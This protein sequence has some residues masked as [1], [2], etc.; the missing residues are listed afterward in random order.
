ML[1]GK[2]VLAMFLIFTL[3]FSN[4]AFVAE[5]FASTGFQTIFSLID[6]KSQ[7]NIEFE[8]LL[9]DGNNKSA[10]IVSD[11]NSKNLSLELKLNVKNS[12]YLKDGKVALVT[13][14]KELNFVIKEDNN[15]SELS[16]VQSLAENTLELKKIESSASNIEISLPIEYKMEEYINELKLDSKTHVI[17]T[18]IYVDNDGEEIEISKENEIELAWK[19]ERTVKVENEVSKFIKF[20]EN[21]AILQTLIKVDSSNEEQNSLPI[22]ETEL[23]INIP[24]INNI[25]PTNVT[26][27]ANSTAGTNGKG[28]G[29]VEFSNDNWNYNETEKQIN[30]KVQNKKE[31]VNINSEEYLKVEGEEKQEERYF[32]KTGIDEYIVTYTFENV[33]F[34]NVGIVNSNVKAN[35]SILSGVKLE[36]NE[37]I[38]EAE[39]QEKINLTEQTGNIVSYNIENETKDISKIYGYLN[40]EIELKSKT[41]INISYTDILEEIVVE[42]LENYYTDKSGDKIATN[43]V[44]YKQILV[45]KDNFNEIL[46]ENG[47]IEILDMAGNILTTINNNNEVDENGNYVVN[48]QD[49]ISKIQI[50]TSK[51]V[52]TGNLVVSNVKAVSNVDMKKSEYS[53]INYLLT[54]TIQKA[55]FTYVQDYVELGNK[56]VKTILNDTTTDFNLSID[57]QS[58]STATTN[59]DV[60]LRLELNNDEV[61]SDL[62]GNSVFEIEMP[63][64]VISMDITNASIIYGE[65]LN[66]SNIETFARDNKIV[67]KVEVEGNQTDLNSGVLTNGT[68][69]VLNTDIDV[70]MYA[71]SQENNIKAYCYNSEAT[72][73]SNAVEYII[74]DSSIAEY[75]EASI[76]YLA[77]N[78]VV[79]IN[80]ISN[81]DQTGKMITSI[82]EGDK[83]DYIDIYSNAKNATME[84]ALINNN[85]NSISNL[86]ILGRIPFEGVTDIENGNKLGTTLNAKLLG[87][88]MANENNNA[89]FKVY[90]SNNPNATKDLLDSL[91]GWTNNPENF[92][93][94][95]SYLIVPTDSSYVM[96]EKSVLRFTY[97]FEIPENLEHNEN[98]YGTFMAYYTN[99]TQ[100][101]TIEE[102]A[103][104]DKV[105]IT[106]G[107]GP[108]LNLDIMTDTKSI[109]ALDTLTSTVVVKN[110]GEDIVN[111]V[112]VT[113]PVPENTTFVSAKPNVSTATTT[114]SDSN[115][116]INVEKLEK[117]SSVEVTLKLNINDITEY[118]SDKFEIVA[119]V[120]AK[121]LAKSLIVKSEEIS[122]VRSEIGIKQY[123]DYEFSEETFRAGRELN[124]VIYVENLTDKKLNNINVETTLPQ[125]LKF[126]EGYVVNGNKANYDSSSN[127]VTWNIPSLSVEEGIAL[128]LNVTVGELASGINQKNVAVM[129]KVSSDE[130]ESYDAQNMLVNVGKT[131]VTI[132]QTSSTSTYVKEGETIDYTFI[133]KNEGSTPATDILLKES[134]P[135]GVIIRKISY[136]VDGAEYVETMSETENAEVSLTV[137]A[138]SE[139][140]VNV[141]ALASTLQDEKEKSITNVATIENDGMNSMTSNSVTHIIQ[142]KEELENGETSSTNNGIIS[143]PATNGDIT[144]SY[145]ITGT[146]WLD[147]NKNGMRDD[148]ETRMSNITAMLVESSTGTI[149]S[150]T[151]TSSN[152]EYTFSGVQNGS[153][154]VLFKYD[155]V[156]YTTTT[157][158]KEGVETSVNSD[159]VTTKIEQDGKKENGAV[160]DIVSVNGASISNIDIGLV[161]AD[162]FSLELDKTISKI[163]VQNSQGTKTEEFDNTKLA[164][165]DIAAKYL[166]GTKVYIEYKFTVKNNG[167][168]SGYASEIV[169]YIPEGMTFNSNLNPDW[170]TG[171]NGNLYTKALANTEIASGESK[172][173]TLVLTK[174]MTTEN[175]GLVS[176]TAEISDDYNIYG[177]SDTNSTPSNKAQGEDDIS[178]ADTIL[179]VKTGESLIYLSAIIVSLLIGSMITVCGIKI[180]RNKRKGGV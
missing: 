96:K 72:N 146:A 29:E 71:P 49:K 171:I 157:Y 160:T 52:N 74:K 158:R 109:R 91:N 134:I 30:I 86:A 43:D 166:S 119:T 83:V 55:K 22:K 73:Y 144:K 172:T 147:K 149:K 84:I 152:G 176:N 33:D 169:D 145:K 155:T 66:I 79:A 126:L 46:G 10:V 51:L 168:L 11:V 19:D 175:T 142:A 8:A 103:K 26:V 23:N 122:I 41:A 70:D 95:K 7:D 28:V 48:F 50:K 128:K 123:M 148:G 107:A 18:G 132:T 140:E 87:E 153:Y 14:D 3:T 180:V 174:Q 178:T 6:S 47:Y 56:I 131:S 101:A 143:T 81:Y 129:T 58:L 35:V 114:Y 59:K 21:G 116:I 34:E 165:Y 57:K 113:I 118:D 80:T 121:D 151:T 13:D 104:P 53:N 39:K 177:I 94:I 108:K 1:R 163:T 173:I 102:V 17:L 4:F 76:D 117:D 88:I 2:K 77:P 61:T 167:D 135:N 82:K 139:L 111:D 54:D 25:N 156:L 16:I 137:G 92:E 164:K 179:T 85:E 124:F 138:N 42:D 105:G 40:K 68:N 110:M 78:G 60:E 97:D 12:G 5:S 99:N 161:E 106:T 125:E 150:T 64:N 38:T 136:T 37:T 90:Y 170:Y 65:G 36:N 15:I 159:V 89:S 115:I 133:I 141:Q 69:I 130:T 98:I 62:Y 112:V 75:G 31:L 9:S 63:E 67:A 100:K 20:S 93:A 154:L 162:K 27:I 44:Y 45:S 127:K 32:S 120:E 24:T